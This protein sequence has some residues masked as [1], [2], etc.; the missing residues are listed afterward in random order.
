MVKPDEFRQKRLSE[1][2]RLIV[3]H[4]AHPL[5]EL[6]RRSEFPIAQELRLRVPNQFS[7]AVILRAG[8][9]ERSLITVDCLNHGTH[10]ARARCDRPDL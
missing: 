6:R 1:D 3:H 7:R 4:H 2:R 8:H 9:R 10:F 5:P